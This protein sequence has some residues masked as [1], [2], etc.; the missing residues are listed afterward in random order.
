[1]TF[2]RWPPSTLFVRLGSEAVFRWEFKFDARDDWQSSMQVIWAKTDNNG[3]IENKYITV[4]PPAKWEVNS[5]QQQV[6][7]SIASRIHWTGNFSRDG[8][9]QVFTLSNVSNSDD[10][11]YGCKVEMSNGDEFK[12]GPIKL[13]FAGK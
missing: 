3:I 11:F 2:T 1:M 12:N 5:N 7:Q 10:I 13:D 9:L 6:S 4:T 8:S